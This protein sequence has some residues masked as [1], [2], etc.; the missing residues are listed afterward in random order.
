M[1]LLSVRR[2]VGEFRKRYK[3]MALAAVL[4]F[5]ALLARLGYLQLVE[6]GKWAAVARRN[7]TKIVP[8]P[9]TRGIVRDSRSNVLAANRPAYALY[10][11]PSK[12]AEADLLRI[13]ELMSLEAQERA[14]MRR[15][16]EA[17]PA[18]RRDHLIRVF[19]DI[20]RDQFAALQT[21]ARDLPGV[22][23]VVL[24][25][26]FY[27]HDSLGA[28]V[29][30]FV[31][32]VN[33]DDLRR[34]AERAY[35]P[36]QTIGRSG[37][38][39]AWESYLRGRD[40]ELRIEVD[41]R[42]RELNR[43][44]PRLT[45][46]RREP[47]AGRDL[48]T[49]L[50]MN[51]M[52]VVN[53]AFRGHPSGGAVALEIHTGR[54]R[55]LYSKPS[56]DLNAMSGGIAEERYRKI[57]AD[58]FR[59]LIDKALYESYFPGSTFKPISALAAL[60]DGILA[61]SNR[62]E[63]GGFYQL[64]RRKFRC[65]H[66]HGDP[67]MRRALIESC[68]VYFYRLAELVG[69]NRMTQLAR[70]FGLGEATG[71]GLDEARGFLPTREWYI[72]HYGS[73]YRLG[74]T[75]NAAIGQGNTRATLLQLALAYAAI[76]NGGKMYV[77]QL[78]QSMESPDGKIIQTFKPRIRRR[79]PV[80]PEHLAYVAD[81]LVGVVNDAKGTAF[82]AH[83][84]GGVR[85]AGKTGT[86]QVAR[87]APRP[88]EDPERAWYLRRSHAWFAG[89]APAHAPE[90]AVVVLVEHGGRGGRHAAPIAVQILQEALG[91]HTAKLAIETEGTTALVNSR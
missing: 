5:G 66:V 43:D 75:L 1:T 45:G 34:Y 40:G 19:S 50:D 2:E 80:D 9:A 72:K 53:R 76:A 68:N 26:R 4:A 37:I 20:S 56:Y 82:E 52:R 48:T 47:I 32:E 60:Q 3:W 30:G 54:I 35:R 15:R 17:V 79:V 44:K 8:L 81:S 74:F 90:M 49:T 31:N 87:R 59:P 10:I 88:H 38:E 55:A 29:I 69:L 21:H 13:A 63:C 23:T 64:G 6:H 51:L 65:S 71:V 33:A 86:A 41:V 46:E 78:I 11:T 67:D 24:P 22:A 73:Q 57:E 89:F 70:D 39:Q 61:P 16:L 42:G 7:I 25:V 58:P 91:S 28:H 27:P 18:R 83:V 85:V 77:P 12:V 36:G 62:F 14:A 84:E